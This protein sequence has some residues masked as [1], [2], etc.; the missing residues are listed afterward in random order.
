MT[1]LISLLRS[2]LSDLADLIYYEVVT[3]D[4]TKLTSEFHEKYPGIFIISIRKGDGY[5][6]LSVNDDQCLLPPAHAHQISEKE[7]GV[8]IFELT[9]SM[10]SKRALSRSPIRT[11]KRS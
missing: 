6:N 4:F 8:D 5:A 10:N 9:S 7:R 2:E 3:D 11:A 1:K